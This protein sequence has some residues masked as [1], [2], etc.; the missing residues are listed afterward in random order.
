MPRPAGRSLPACLCRWPVGEGGITL[1]SVAIGVAIVEDQKETREG[2]SFLIRNSRQFECRHVYGSMEAALEG[3]GD[4]PPRI[5]LVD[6]GLPGMSGID[7]VRV[8]RERYSGISP[9]LLTVFKDDDRIFQA[10]CAGACGYLLKTT[11]PGKLLEA[12]N[13][14]PPTTAWSPPAVLSSPPPMTDA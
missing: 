10:I 9:V 11:P 6:I 1:C 12:L 8:L 13:H 14:P 5:A 2:L 7:G 3:I 4:H